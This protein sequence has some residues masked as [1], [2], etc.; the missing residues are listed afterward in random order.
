MEW[1]Q[2]KIMKN[3]K[4]ILDE[5]GKLVGTVAVDSQYGSFL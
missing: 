1:N 2:L 5:F 4:D 3:D